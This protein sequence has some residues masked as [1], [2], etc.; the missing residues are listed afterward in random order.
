MTLPLHI[1]TYLG[2][3]IRKCP[4]F[5]ESS[6]VQFKSP[7][8]TAATPIP[9]RCHTEVSSTGLF[10]TRMGE[11]KELLTVS[12]KT[13]K[14]LAIFSKVLYAI[15]I[16][17]YEGMAIRDDPS[18]STEEKTLIVQTALRFR[19]MKYHTNTQNVDLYTALSLEPNTAP[20]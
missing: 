14:R 8:P 2:V 12:I 5:I 6:H 15:E 20:S 19:A 3:E 13:F 9:V 16:Q 17:G 1:H 7:L 10:M 18:F 11:C 4:Y